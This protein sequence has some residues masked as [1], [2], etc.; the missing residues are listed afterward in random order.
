MPRSCQAGVQHSLIVSLRHM[1]FRCHSVLFLTLLVLG[2]ACSKRAG[3]DSG[4]LKDA[5]VW[6]RGQKAYR[7][8]LA[9]AAFGN[10]LALKKQLST[11]QA[12]GR[13]DLEYVYCQAVVNGQLFVLAEDLGDT[14]ASESYFQE[15]AGYWRVRAAKL[16]LPEQEYSQAMVKDL[17]QE[18][19]AHSG[20]VLW[21]QET[22]PQSHE[23]N[24]T[25]RGH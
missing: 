15:S 24:S 14:N 25:Q 3:P 11:M 12:A 17:I 18:Y 8:N 19:D 16:C 23:T 2:P 7:T 21:R 1:S 22:R 20:P 5:L 13:K 6:D 10:L 4:V 9:P